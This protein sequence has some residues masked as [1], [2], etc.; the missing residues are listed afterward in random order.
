M[1]NR[2]AGTIQV[3]ANGTQYD[4]KGNWSYNLGIPKRETMP[5]ADKPGHGYKET[6]QASFIEGEITDASTLALVDLLTIDDATINLELANGKTIMLRDAYYAA[7]GNVGTAEANVQV[8][9]ESSEQGEE[10][11]A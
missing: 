3:K 9:F 5:G 8:R 2:R 6:Q 10:I 1:P 7:D 11:A 4:A